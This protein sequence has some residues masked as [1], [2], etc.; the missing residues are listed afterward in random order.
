ME[1]LLI[2][3][4]DYISIENIEILREFLTSV[5]S[6]NRS[7][8]IRKCLYFYGNG[9]NGKNTFLEKIIDFIG[10]DKVCYNDDLVNRQLRIFNE[11]EGNIRKIKKY[12]SGDL[13]FFKDS[14]IEQESKSHVICIG[15]IDYNYFTDE[16]FKYRLIPIEFINTF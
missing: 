11:V 15:N 6:I 2:D 12:T 16:S 7:F 3:A 13:A 10:K 5:N 8:N 4:Q 14:K 1:Q 9:N